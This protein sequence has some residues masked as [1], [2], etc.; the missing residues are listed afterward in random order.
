[1]TQAACPEGSRSD[2]LVTLL[3]SAARYFFE[4]G[5]L[6]IDL[7][8]DGG[9]MAFAPQGE[10]ELA[11]APAEAVLSSGLPLAEIGNDEG[12][13]A[14][15]TGEM[16]YTSWYVS[17][18]VKSP[19]VALMDLS[20]QIQG[21]Y[22]EFIPRSGQVVGRLTSPFGPS[23]TSYRIN[24]PVQPEGQYVDLDN[25]GDGPVHA[26]SPGRTGWRLPSTMRAACFGPAG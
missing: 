16:A 14:F 20:S 26:K 18:Y 25:D 22:S 2:Q 17:E 6:F 7:L 15:V 3:G 24:L 9:T 1:M 23:P 11:E 8:A 4:D 12:G 5:Q 10:A 19:V 21:N 13:A